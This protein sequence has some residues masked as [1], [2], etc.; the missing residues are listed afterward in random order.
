PEANRLGEDGTGF[1]A[2]LAIAMPIFSL[3]ASAVAVGFMES[4]TTNACQHAAGSRFEHADS[5]IADLPT[6]RAFLARMRIAT[7]QARLLVEDTAAAMESGR[8]DATLRVL[9][10]KAAAGESATMV[11]DLA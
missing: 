9:E 4:A 7:D 8:A 10:C 11:L 6:A 3:C 5:T 1:D 2:M